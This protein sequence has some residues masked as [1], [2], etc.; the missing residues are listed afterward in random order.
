[1]PV[2]GVFRA[3]TERVP[4][5]YRACS[6]PVSI[7]LRTVSRLRILRTVPKHCDGAAGIIPKK[8]KKKQSFRFFFIGLGE[9]GVYLP[10]VY[11]IKK[12]EWTKLKN[13][14]NK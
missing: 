13:L 14:F 4:C 11:N 1:M 8:N 2:S 12:E 7:T 6:V 10:T 3:C 5:L 9:I